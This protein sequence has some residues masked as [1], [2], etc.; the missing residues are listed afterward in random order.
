MT[1][2]CEKP[3]P[4]GTDLVDQAD[5]TAAATRSACASVWS[6]YEMTMAAVCARATA[7]AD[8]LAPPLAGQKEADFEMDA[9]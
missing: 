9:A 2:C 5:H 4:H 8:A 3:F 1:I 6:R 7:V